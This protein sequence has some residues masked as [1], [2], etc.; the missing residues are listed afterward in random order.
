MERQLVIWVRRVSWE[1]T[2][3]AGESLVFGR[4]ALFTSRQT[5]KR[6]TKLWKQ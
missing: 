6:A 5:G 3:N 2:A 1:L 4:A